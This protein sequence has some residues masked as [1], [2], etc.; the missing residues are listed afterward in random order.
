[1]KVSNNKIEFDEAD[2][3][4]VFAL[5]SSPSAYELKQ[6]DDPANEH[7]LGRVN[8]TEEYELSYAKQDFA[9]DA[10][11]AVL[12]FLHRHGYRIEKDGEVFSLGGISEYFIE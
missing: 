3:K 12:A 11:R 4:E 6:V 7:Y 9:E 2:L 8:L 10:L 1:M 5:F